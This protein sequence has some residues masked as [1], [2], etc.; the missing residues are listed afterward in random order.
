MPIF[1]NVANISFGSDLILP[2]ED[3]LYPDLRIAPGETFNGSEAFYSRFVGSPE[4]LLERTTDGYLTNGTVLTVPGNFISFNLEGFIKA[5]NVVASAEDA[6]VNS[7]VT[8]GTSYS[9]FGFVN[10]D[11]GTGTEF[12]MPFSIVGD[13]DHGVLHESLFALGAAVPAAPAV[14]P[15]IAGSRI[16]CGE[17]IILFS[18][19]GAGSLNPSIETVYEPCKQGY[20]LGDENIMLDHPNYCVRTTYVLAASIPSDNYVAGSTGSIRTE[21]T[22]LS[23][24]KAGDRARMRTYY[25]QDAANPLK[26]THMFDEESIVLQT[27]LP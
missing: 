1:R 13:G 2:R 8:A 21:K 3:G 25:Y 9:A 20:R 26:A 6:A 16:S 18:M 15:Q 24:A 12:T 4:F 10:W 22:F 5:T 11:D 23:G 19:T 27:D 7:Q 14:S 17:G